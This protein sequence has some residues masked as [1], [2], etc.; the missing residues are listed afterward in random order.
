MS[1]A[2]CSDEPQ[3]FRDVQVDSEQEQ[4]PQN[5]R[6]HG[7]RNQPDRVQVLEVVVRGGDGDADDQVDDSEE[8]RS[9]HV[10]DGYPDRGAP[11]L[12]EPGPRKA[13]GR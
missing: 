6:E 1:A 3:L 13:E 10:R 7:R 8:A 11:K 2:K 9:E 5:D 4:R 12:E